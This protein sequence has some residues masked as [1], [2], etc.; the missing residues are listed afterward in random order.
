MLHG[1]PSSSREGLHS[2]SISQRIFS[3][4]SVLSEI[5]SSSGPS[6]DESSDKS[7]GSPGV[8]GPT[9]DDMPSDSIWDGVGELP[10]DL[11]DLDG[12]KEF[13]E[14]PGDLK[15]RAEIKNENGTEWHT[16]TTTL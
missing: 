2:A 3:P 4:S 6:T 11:D 15:G 16:A 9:S 12:E 5:S 14:V 7:D 10:A 1:T 8:S 13:H